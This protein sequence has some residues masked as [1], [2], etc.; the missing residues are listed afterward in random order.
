MAHFT[1]SAFGDEIDADLEA[2]LKLLSKIEVNYLEFRS[3]WG[4][5]VTKL[6]GEQIVEA[7]KLCRQYGI[8]VSC[9]GSPIGKSPIEDPLQNE[10]ENMERLFRVGEALDSNR[11]RLFSF[12]P[13]DTTDLASYDDYVDESIER[14]AKLTGLAEKAGFYLMFENEK[15][16]VGDNLERCAEI[17]E[18]INSP[19]FRFAWDSA[20]FI[21]VGVE[22]PVTNG[23]SL[24]GEYTD[25]HVHIKDALSEDGSVTPAGAG[26]GEIP[27]LLQKLHENDFRGFLA[28]EPHLVIAGHSGGFSGVDG[29]TRAVEALRGLLSDLGYEEQ[30]SFGT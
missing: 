15:H 25:T 20:N 23:W 13:P 4:V 11:I 8:K 9:L 19:H 22:E 12:Y 27:L 14:L 28:V 24:L 7:G 18:T 30:P 26:D 1:L 6:D 17:L 5:N 21:Q 10:I 29:M 16:V 2:Q 3:A